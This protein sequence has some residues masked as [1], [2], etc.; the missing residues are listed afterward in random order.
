MTS[1]GG[2]CPPLSPIDLLVYLSLV[3]N[4]MDGIS[5]LKSCDLSNDKTGTGRT[6]TTPFQP[7]QAPVGLDRGVPEVPLLGTDGSVELWR[8]PGT[9]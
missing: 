8:P 7:F 2:C 9:Y 4:R 6:P 1:G 5:I 3:F